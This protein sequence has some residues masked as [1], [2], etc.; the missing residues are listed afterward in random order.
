LGVGVV[1]SSR[2]QLAGNVNIPAPMVLV[3]GALGA[4][5]L[6]NLSGTNTIYGQ[7]NG[8]YGNNYWPI[9]STSGQ[10]TISTFNNA[11]GNTTYGRTLQLQG[12]GNGIITNIIDSSSTLVNP[13]GLN[14][15]MLEKDGAGIWTISGP[16][17]LTRGVTVNAGALVIDANG[18]INA[19]GNSQ[20]YNC[21][22]AGGTFLVNGSVTLSPSI[23]ANVSGGQLGGSG[24]INGPVSVQTG[25]SLAP[26]AGFST[27]TSVLTINGP[28][29][30]GGNLNLTLNKSLVQSNDLVNVLGNGIANIGAG[31]VTVT[32]NGPALVTGDRFMLFNQPVTNGASLNLNSIVRGGLGQYVTWSNHL[33]LDGGI[34]VLTVAPL[35]TNAYLN[36]LALNPADN[37]TPTFATNLFV[38]YATN[39]SGITPTLTVTNASLTASNELILNGLAF[40]VLTSGVPS[41]ALTS[42]GAGSTN[43]LKVLVTAQDGVTTNLYS[44]NLTQLVVN[45]NTFALK[46]GVSA[47]NLNLAWP[48]DRLGWRLWV[49]TNA[50]NTGLGT[51]WFVWPNSTTVTNVSIPLNSANPSVFLRMTYP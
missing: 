20:C 32:N 10:L 41:M 6:E 15:L 28:L 14:Y 24:I 5:N 2:L 39:A 26:T 16:A 17:D 3:S 36:S 18:I 25:G 35:G 45:T 51:N 43:V 40:Q 11:I 12:A 13:S 33:A 23:T 19:G 7:V 42:L 27:N 31:L 9:A 8:V 38:Y 50:L 22:V 49:Q 1:S 47:G 34:S 29:V 21:T 30:L 46:S 4:Q 48:P 37:L 44:V